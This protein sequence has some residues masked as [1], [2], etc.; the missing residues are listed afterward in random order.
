MRLLRSLENQGL[1]QGT[2]EDGGWTF[3]N[4]IGAER[5]ENVEDER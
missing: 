1:R 5:Q 4:F 2:A 3:I